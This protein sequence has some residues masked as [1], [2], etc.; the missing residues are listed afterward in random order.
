MRPGQTGNG[1]IAQMV[2]NLVGAPDLDMRLF[3]RYASAGAKAADGDDDALGQTRVL[4]DLLE[5]VDD[6][7]L[8]R[9]PPCLAFHDDAMEASGV[10]LLSQYVDLVYE[11]APPPLL[12]VDAC[13][14]AIALEVLRDP[15]FEVAPRRWGRRHPQT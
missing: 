15:L 9:R 1:V 2:P 12:V 5:L 13:R 7:L 14:V 8:D 4:H 6:V 3:R 11:P 10:A